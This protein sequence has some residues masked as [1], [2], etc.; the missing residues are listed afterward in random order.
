MARTYL[1]KRC[2]SLYIVCELGVLEHFGPKIRTKR[3]SNIHKDFELY[4]AF[5]PMPKCPSIPI[6]HIAYIKNREDMV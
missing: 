5:L 2:S 4:Q 3:I 6:I 1:V